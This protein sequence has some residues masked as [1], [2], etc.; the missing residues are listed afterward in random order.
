MTAMTDVSS[1]DDAVAPVAEVRMTPA[2]QTYLQILC[3]LLGDMLHSL[4]RVPAG[5]A[6]VIGGQER[7]TGA[8][9]VGFLYRGAVNNPQAADKAYPGSWGGLTA[10]DAHDRETRSKIMA[11]LEDLQAVSED[12]LITVDMSSG[13]LAASYPGHY[14]ELLD[15]FAEKYRICLD[16]A[17]P[18]SPAT[19][20]KPLSAEETHARLTTNALVLLRAP[21]DRA[22]NPYFAAAVREEPSK[23]EGKGLGP[24]TLYYLEDLRAAAWS[25]RAPSKFWSPDE[26]PFRLH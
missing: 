2:Q 4:Y 8:L 11:F 5:R 10:D 3:T 19:D 6:R 26:R 18:L 21:T 25:L 17:L 13:R 12:D 24:Y 16:R 15:R 9:V 7:E 23:T 14:I 20:R 22:L 1:G